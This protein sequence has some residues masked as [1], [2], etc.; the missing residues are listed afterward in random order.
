MTHDDERP[1]GADALNRV[2]WALRRAEWAVQARKDQRLRPQG[3]AAAQYTLLIS[4]HSDPGLT[5]AE[6]ARRLNVT[7]QAIASQVTRLEER[8]QLERRPHPRHRHVQE[9]HLTDAGRDCLRDADAVIVEIE[10]R[11]AEKLGSK[12][13]AQLRALLD[14]VADVVREA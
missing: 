11:I 6:L 5:G 1:I 12:K 3:I 13:A 9:L 2:T 7:P 4:V 14:E 8:G 10:Q